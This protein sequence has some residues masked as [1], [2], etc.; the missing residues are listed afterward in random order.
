MFTIKLLPGYSLS[1][2][3]LSSIKSCFLQANTESFG[4]LEIQSSDI[5][6]SVQKSELCINWSDSLD[7][8]PLTD[9]LFRDES[10]H[11]A[12]LH[13]MGKLANSNRALLGC[14]GVLVCDSAVVCKETLVLCPIVA[15]QEV[16]VEQMVYKH[17]G[18]CMRQLALLAATVLNKGRNPFASKNSAQ[19][20]RNMVSLRLDRCKIEE[21]L[22]QPLLKLFE[23]E[24]ADAFAKNFGA[25]C[26]KEQS[27]EQRPSNIQEA[28]ARKQEARKSMI[29]PEVLV[30]N[31][32]DGKGQMSEEES[33]LKSFG[34][35]TD[36]DDDN[37]LA[38][39]EEAK[40]SSPRPRESA[41]LLMGQSIN[42]EQFN[43]D[44]DEIGDFDQIAELPNENM[45]GVLL[46][47]RVLDG[48]KSLNE[49]INNSV[50]FNKVQ[51]IQ[52]GKIKKGHPGFGEQESEVSNS[53]GSGKKSSVAMSNH[54]K[55]FED[56]DLESEKEE[57]NLND[58]GGDDHPKLDN[59][60]SEHPSG[61]MSQRKHTEPRSQG[62]RILESLP[63][64]MLSMRQP[65]QISFII[66]LEPSFVTGG[67]PISEDLP[68]FEK[69]YKSLIG[70]SPPDEEFKG[71]KFIYFKYNSGFKKQE[72]K[73]LI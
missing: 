58:S 22:I 27:L 18:G 48:N 47:D 39:P 57:E 10:S 7:S 16:T 21:G 53:R 14:N 4:H 29:K 49:S 59:R 40:K 70:I 71:L 8:V 67:Q 15:N 54:I 45:K 12:K 50:D 25:L 1:D 23:S 31:S 20:R 56:F 3:D 5:S 65:N 61:L 28:S 63:A 43:L 32:S 72:G 51:K 35:L 44:E 33:V 42:S 13:L 9:F 24:N 34:Q 62:S 11:S 19:A 37:E 41:E 55:N 69:G 73:A 68:P 64:S 36:G 60:I 26:A 66:N 38:L 17:V 52:I 2:D 30:E 46:S 6:L